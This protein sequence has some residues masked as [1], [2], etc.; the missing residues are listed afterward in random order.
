MPPSQGREVLVQPG[1][2]AGPRRREGG[3]GR[4]STH[5]ETARVSR[6]SRSMPP[7][8]HFGGSRARLRAS[9]AACGWMGAAAAGTIPNPMAEPPRSSTPP[10]PA[11]PG[12]PSPGSHHPGDTTVVTMAPVAPEALVAGTVLSSSATSSLCPR[13][14]RTPGSPPGR[15]PHRWQPQL[16]VCR[17]DA[18]CPLPAGHGGGKPSS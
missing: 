15:R 14:P 7:G 17:R 2:P 16:V 18:R 1:S 3:G 5:R 12:H 13:C 6:E 8:P 4:R 10:H 11:Q 9:R